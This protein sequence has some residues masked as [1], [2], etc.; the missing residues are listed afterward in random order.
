VASPATLHVK[1]VGSNVRMV[2]IPDVPA[3][4]AAQL[5]STSGPTGVTAPSPV[6]TTR[7]FVIALP[8]KRKS[9]YLYAGNGLNSNLLH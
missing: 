7:R 3:I 6:T 9:R 2:S 8:K 5:D 1:P 4:N